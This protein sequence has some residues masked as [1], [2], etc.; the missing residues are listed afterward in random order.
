MQ[1]LKDAY[2]A[3]GYVYWREKRPVII[4]H[5]KNGGTVYSCGIY[6]PQKFKMCEITTIE[7]YL[8]FEAFQKEYVVPSKWEQIKYFIRE[9]I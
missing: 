3:D 4:K 1:L 9:K 8:E 6:S 2:R 5:L 7:Q